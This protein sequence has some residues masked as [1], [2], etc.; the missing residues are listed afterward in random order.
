MKKKKHYEEKNFY[1]VQKCQ[2]VSFRKSPPFA[3]K[4]QRR[5]WHHFVIKTVP[6]LQGRGVAVYGRHRE[7]CQELSLKLEGGTI[8]N[9]LILLSRVL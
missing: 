3:E 9:S 8:S 4:D 2:L 1:I 5:G 7:Y 6:W